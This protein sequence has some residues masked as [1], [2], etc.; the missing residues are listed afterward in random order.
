AL[1]YLMVLLAAGTIAQSK[2]GLYA[3]HREY[4]SSWI[5]WLGPAPLPGMYPVLGLITLSLSA[6]FLIDC[7]RSRE[8]IGTTLAHLGVLILLYGGLATALTQQEGFMVIAE[9]KSANSISDYH[10]RVLN[11]YKDV[12]VAAEIPCEALQEGQPVDDA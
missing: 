6:K 5:V 8:K 2:I 3:A 9:G 12:T 7:P 4:F 1:P 11:I 10:A